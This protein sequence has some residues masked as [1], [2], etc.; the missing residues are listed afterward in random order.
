ME[1]EKPQLVSATAAIEAIQTNKQPPGPEPPAPTKDT[2]P[3]YQDWE[4]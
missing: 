4:D 2:S 1:Y 3:A